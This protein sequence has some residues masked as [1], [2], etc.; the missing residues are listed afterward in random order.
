MNLPI[1]FNDV[2]ISQLPVYDD[3]PITWE[4]MGANEIRADIELPGVLACPVGAYIIYGGNRYTVNTVPSVVKGSKY[5]YKYTI[6]FESDL[7]RLYDKGL[8]H[9]GNKTFQDYG[10]PADYAQLIVDN[11][12][13][14]DS[15]WTVGACDSAN[16][17][18]I[19][20]DSHTCR[21]AL[22]T[23]AEAF[24]FEWDVTGKVI[25]FVKQVGNTTSL[26]FKYGKGNGLYSL[27]YQ[28]QNDKNIVTRAFGYGSSR[29]LPEGYRGGAKQ[30]M[31]DGL[32][33][34]GNVD[35]YRIKEGNFTDET[36]CPKVEGAVTAVSTYDPTS[37]VFTITDSGLAFD[38]W[39]NRSSQTPVISF[40]TGELQGQEFDILDYDHTTK[41]IKIKVFV[42][43]TNQTLPRVG[44]G[45]AIGDTYTLFDMFMPPEAVT[46]AELELKTKTIEWKDENKVPR[47]LYNLELDPLYARDNGIML[48]PGDK[49]T[50]QDTD[51]GID[52]MI[53]VTSVSYPVN[54]PDVITP[55]TKI[56]AQIANFIPYTQTVRVIAATIDNAKGI[57]IVDRTNAERARLGALNL[58][59]LQGRIFNPDGTLF[60]GP[61]SLVAGMAAF[62]YD[63]QNF[64]LNN[65]TVSPNNGANPNS[66]SISAGDLIH[67]IYKIDG[68]GYDWVLTSHSF[69]GL[70][71]AKFYYV[72][73]KCSKSAL[74][75]TWQISETPVHVNDIPGYF[76]FN[77]GILYEVNTSGYRDFEFTKGMTY[78]VGDTITTGRIKDLTGQNY[79]DLTSGQFNLG[80]ADMGIDFDVTTPATLTI[81][82]A[83]ASKV[84]QVGSA[85]VINA[86]ISGVTDAGTS[87][88]R[89]WAGETAANKNTAPF[90]VTD[91]GKVTLKSGLTG[92]RIVISSADNSFKFYNSAGALIIDIDDNIAPEGVTY[93]GTPP[94]PVYTNGPGIFIGESGGDNSSIGRKGIQTSGFMNS[95]SIL[96]DD[97]VVNSSV[98]FGNAVIK[99]A[100]IDIPADY[101]IQYVS[102]AGPDRKATFKNGLL[103]KD[104]LL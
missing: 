102:A 73:A 13:E 34:D 8:K 12:N 1:N 86:G 47:V 27:G 52:T 71:P 44:V 57:K 16:E 100:G 28:Y 37:S 40:L 65:V 87:S 56:T 23:I 103:W 93:T 99:T 3:L 83:L 24:K 10:S 53:R 79:L 14:I 89:F 17:Q 43:S 29:N 67:R 97:L 94:H 68:L 6:V 84:I 31:F 98:D 33:V 54:F 41:I 7:Y 66:M 76:A 5:A 30:L 11:I 38:I 32:Y 22:D 58:K 55:S 59:T 96:T 9:L 15:G 62:G 81:R 20:F 25:K 95:N 74:V 75:G 70:D 61:D 77:L 64:N 88:V 39:A 48:K 46:A 69:T 51:L 2:I 90:R 78:I 18:Y 26:V 49:V 101:V 50:V 45:A 92:Q 4:L 63:S 82:G 60:D 80:D 35:I 91:D 19:N 85:G 104:E 72:Y 42:D 36:I 21:T